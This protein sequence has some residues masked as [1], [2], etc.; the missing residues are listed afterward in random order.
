MT[1]DDSQCPMVVPKIGFAASRASTF[2]GAGNGLGPGTR[3]ISVPREAATNTMKIKRKICKY[4]DKLW[5]Y[6]LH[7]GYRDSTAILLPIGRF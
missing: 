2:V 1:R 6:R 7:I 3:E 5:E 4:N